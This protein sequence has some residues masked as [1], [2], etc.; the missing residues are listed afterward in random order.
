M[1]NLLQ[2]ASLLWA[3]PTIFLTTLM[4]FLK[5]EQMSKIPGTIMLREL[6][7]QP[8]IILQIVTTHLF[9]HN[10][11]P[12]WTEFLA[13]CQEDTFSMILLQEEKQQFLT[14]LKNY[15]DGLGKD[16][17]DAFFGCLSIQN[18]DGITHTSSTTAPTQTNG[19]DVQYSMQS[20]LNGVPLN[21]SDWPQNAQEIGG[22]IQQFISTS[23]QDKTY[24]CS[25]GTHSGD[26]LVH[27]KLTPCSVIRDPAIETNQQWM[28]VTKVLKYTIPILNKYEY[29][30]QELKFVIQE[31]PQNERAKKTLEL[32]RLVEQE[33][34]NDPESKK[35][36]K[37]KRSWNSSTSTRHRPY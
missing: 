31:Y 35:E 16:T 19:A 12:T 27:I 32:L 10:E 11:R 22:R 36:V 24:S 17:P 37:P 33:I 13:S 9:E 26:L 2:L 25:L 18:Q 34:T 7:E 8:K 28:H 3:T 14:L 30:P 29:S 1:Y 5:S 23:R 6:T 4:K 21:Q 20:L 15:Y